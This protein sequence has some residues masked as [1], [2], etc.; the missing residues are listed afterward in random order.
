MNHRP[1]TTVLRRRHLFATGCIAVAFTHC[2]ASTTPQT[3]TSPRPG[4]CWEGHIPGSN[5]LAHLQ[6]LGRSCGQALGLSPM[7]PVQR[8]TQ[9]EDDPAAL[10]VLQVPAS[11][12]C[13]RWVAVGG[14]GVQDVDLLA[15]LDG[16]PLAGDLSAD[17]T[18]VLPA[19]GPLCLPGAASLTLEM[20]V[21]RGSGEVLWQLWG[22]IPA[23]NNH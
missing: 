13:Y 23:P 16:V 11:G 10:M 6:A 7:G 22:G 14:D 2:S 20:S 19:D 12:A 1:H 5:R 15:Q 17:A 3:A 8:L 9:R 18:P 4:S 21:F